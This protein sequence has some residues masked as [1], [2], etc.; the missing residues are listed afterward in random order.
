MLLPGEKLHLAVVSLT[1]PL[2]RAR[3]ARADW[4]GG[5]DLSRVGNEIVGTEGVLVIVGDLGFERSNLLFELLICASESVGFNAMDGIAVLDSGNKALGDLFDSFIGQV[6]SE[7]VDGG[8]GGDWARDSCATW[9]RISWSC[10]LRLVD[11]DG[12]SCGRPFF[13]LMIRR[14]PRSTLFPYTT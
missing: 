4:D 8:L 1:N 5:G 7:Y 12:G 10:R 6:L 14:P 13:F 2:G 3:I 11:D 9:Q